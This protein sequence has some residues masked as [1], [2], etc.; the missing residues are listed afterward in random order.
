MKKKYLST[1]ELPHVQY[2]SVVSNN[3]FMSGYTTRERH[4]FVLNR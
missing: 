1:T 3:V 2:K 4:A